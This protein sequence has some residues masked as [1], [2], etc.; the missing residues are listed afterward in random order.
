[1]DDSGSLS[2]SASFSA[3]LVEQA[4]TLSRIDDVTITE[5]DHYGLNCKSLLVLVLNKASY[6]I[7]QQCVYHRI[8]G[9]AM[10]VSGIFQCRFSLFQYP[11][12]NCTHCGPHYSII[13][14]LPYDRTTNQYARLCAVS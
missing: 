2:M 12:T 14:A 7:A 9:F 13:K 4:P 11:F 5:F 8:K 10:L 6:V 3:Q 1:M